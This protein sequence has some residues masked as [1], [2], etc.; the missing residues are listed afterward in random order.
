MGVRM[1]S[2]G[3]AFRSILDPRTWLHAV[4][5]AHYASYSHVRQLARIHRG[6]RLIVAPNVSFR[7]AERI[8]LGDSC[9]LGERLSIWA[10][11]HTGRVLI[12]EKCLLGPGAF[13]TA[14][15]YGI[16]RGTWPY[17]QPKAERDVVIG[18]EVWIGANAVVT[19]GVTIG[20]GAIVGAGSVVTHDLP[21]NCI[22]GGV[23][24]RVIGTRPEPSA[25]EPSREELSRE[26][27]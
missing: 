14:S 4:R 11:D 19:A 3:G 22:A 5:L 23:P 25:P 1:A 12:G 24:A 13:I 18:A 17:E 26:G 2:L 21:P 27:A 20:A 6:E 7:N 9:H 16:E 10:G 15:D 8:W